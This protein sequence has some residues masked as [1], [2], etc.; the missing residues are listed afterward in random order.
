MKSRARKT[1]EAFNDGA[2][3]FAQ[4]I[5]LHKCPRRN[6]ELRAAWREGWESQRRIRTGMAATPEQRAASAA[7]AAKLSQWARAR[8]ATF[9][10]QPQS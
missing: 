9:H 2:F 1:E 6:G 7:V 4:R 8:R 3:A 10:T 5:P